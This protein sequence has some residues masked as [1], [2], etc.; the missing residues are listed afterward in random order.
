MT[1][2]CLVHAI[3]ENGLGWGALI[4]VGHPNFQQRWDLQS[5]I[6]NHQLE[7]GDLDFHSHMADSAD[8]IVGG[9]LAVF[10]GDG[11]DGRGLIVRAQD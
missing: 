5:T 1:S 10:H 4:S 3:V 6:R 2:V 7:I 9:G 8:Q 11:F